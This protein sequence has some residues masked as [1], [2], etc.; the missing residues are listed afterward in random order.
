VLGKC[1]SSTIKAC[2]WIASQVKKDTYWCFFDGQPSLSLTSYALIALTSESQARTKYTNLTQNAI[3][4]LEKNIKKLKVNEN[5]DKVSGDLLYNFHH[6]TLPWGIMALLSAGVPPFSSLIQASVQELY[7]DHYSKKTGGWAEEKGHRPSVFATSHTIATLE[8]IYDTITIKDYAMK[9]INQ[10]IPV[11]NNNVFIVHGHDVATK[12]EVARFLEKIGCNPIILEEQI[13]SGAKTIYE[14]FTENAQKAAYAIVLLTPDDMMANV[15][16]ANRA[17]QNVI[18]ELGF[19]IG[20]LGAG[21]VCLA[22]KGNVDIPSDI[23]GVLY[24]NLDDGG[25]KLSLSQKIHSAGLN[26]DLSKLVS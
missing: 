8:K 1:N 18:L 9:E 3:T 12:L 20:T 7:F 21:K 22:K 26:I 25:W 17:R 14:K 24:L 23:S 2:D 13:D 19:F 5:E 16:S 10:S 4:F 15:N 6:Y 11:S